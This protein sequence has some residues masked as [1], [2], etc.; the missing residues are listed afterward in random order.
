MVSSLEI[1]ETQ[2]SS[3]L[4]NIIVGIAKTAESKESTNTKDFIFE[5]CGKTQGKDQIQQSQQHRG[6]LW[7]CMCYSKRVG[8]KR[9][10]GRTKSCVDI[11]FMFQTSSSI[12]FGRA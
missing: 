11:W 8:V 10:V 2:Y 7:S 4:R 1:T 5:I 9:T 6:G 12:S 3:G